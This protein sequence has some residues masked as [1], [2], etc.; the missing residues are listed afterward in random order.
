MKYVNDITRT[1]CDTGVS[2]GGK[3]IYRSTRIEN[4]RNYLLGFEPVLCVERMENYTKSYQ[5]SEAYPTCVRRALAF[6]K[7]VENMT[8]Q[9]LDGELLAGNL[10]SSPRGVPLFPEFSINWMIEELDG[11]PIRPP[12][13]PGD[14]FQI[15]PENEKKVRELAEYWRGKTHEDRCMARMPKDA[16]EAH[17]QGAFNSYWL[18]TGGEGHLT[19]NLKKVA[20]EGLESFHKEVKDKLASLDLQDRWESQKLHFLRS[21]EIYIDAMIA[22]SGRYAKMARELAAECDDGQR[23]AELL[24]MAEICERVPEKPAR[25]F[26]EAIQAYWF[27][28]LCLEIDNNGFAISYG[29]LDKNLYPFYKKDIEEGILTEDDAVEIL[30]SFFLK[31][32][33][34]NRIQN[35]DSTQYFGG[36]QVFQNIT[37]GGQDENG[38]DATNDLSFRILETQ[39]MINLHQPSISLR[40][41]DRIGNKILQAAIDCIKLGGGQPA[42]YSDESYMPALINRGISLED[43]S[44]YSLVGC[45][46]AIV[47]GKQGNRPSGSAYINLGKI[48][49]M[50]LRGGADPVTGKNLHPVKGLLECA[51]YKEFYEN[52]RELFRFYV[53][54]QMIVDTVHDV[55]TEEGIADPLVSLLVD[56]CIKRGQTIKEGGSIYDFIAPQFIGVANLGNCLAAVKRA[57][58]EDELLT[59]EQLL[60]ALE[61]DFADESANPTGKEI[62]KMMMDMPK[63]GNDDDYVDSIM[64]ESF[65]FICEEISKYKNPRYGR[66]PIGGVWQP[67]VSSVSA[68]VPHGLKVGALP[69]GREANTPLSD[70]I[71]PMHGTDVN[72]PT[73]SLKSVSK[74]PTMLVAGGELL[75]MRLNPASVEKEGGRERLIALIR[76]FLGDLKGMHIQFNIIDSETLRDAQA[77]PDQYKDLM[78]RVAG[79]SALFTPLDPML[80]ND[81]IARTEHVL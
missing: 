4:L 5:E 13:R 33:Q 67:S 15:S 71:S 72:G 42:I 23:K 32:F 8:I 78:V 46:E 43:A 63:Y 53:S 48:M 19:V 69:D 34:L 30:G 7:T 31:I 27:I 20:Y 62:Q 3:K 77:H 73:A 58:Y 55:A 81:I 1:H 66:G 2:I 79:Y 26:H 59:K 11:N 49:E 18:M 22:F 37:I 75:N 35:W 28:N 40:Y 70:T 80:Q 16:W 74:I 65:R 21:A 60:H 56:D 68:N 61:T 44:E 12:D 14:S 45:A 76:T 50:A 41:H 39:A 36:Y 38:A 51:S 10:A 17:E 47:E 24:E 6:K 57:I 52:F 9:I 54:Q 29:R 64:T 25:T